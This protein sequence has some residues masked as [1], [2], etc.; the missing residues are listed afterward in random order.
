MCT[1]CS[2]TIGK[3]QI[4]KLMRVTLCVIACVRLLGSFR[5]LVCIEGTGVL[6]YMT[7]LNMYEI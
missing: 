4:R 5:L 2:S 1:E 7:V 6:R 3:V